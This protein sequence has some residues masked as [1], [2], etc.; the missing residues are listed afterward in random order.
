MPDGITP[1]AVTS[2]RPP[3]VG[4]RN[5]VRVTESPVDDPK[6]L[7]GVG[8]LEHILD[9][10]GELRRSAPMPSCST[11]I[12]AIRRRPADPTWLGALAIVATHWRTA[13]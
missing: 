8:S 10:L 2:R 3:K 4:P 7:A 12:T 5:A 13:S 11:P 9:D 6:R 1:F